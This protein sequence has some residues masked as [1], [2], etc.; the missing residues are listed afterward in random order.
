MRKQNKTYSPELKLEAMRLKQEGSLLY[1]EIADQLGISS[2][3]LVKQWM[4]IYRREGPK[5]FYKTRG[6]PKEDQDT[7]KTRIKQLEME[8]TLLKALAL[9]LREELPEGLD[10]EPSTDIEGNSE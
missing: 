5:G 3:D 9:E 8:N 7:L 6:R 1:R 10:I 4:R 2:P